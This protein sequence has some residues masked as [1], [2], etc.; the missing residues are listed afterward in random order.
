MAI[1]SPDLTADRITQWLREARATTT[2]E[3]A[4]DRTLVRSVAFS[5]HPGFDFKKAKRSLHRARM[6]NEIKAIRPFRA[7]RRNQEAVNEGLV[8]ALGAL[9]SVNKE[10]ASELE[11]L[12]NDIAN[13]RRQLAEREAATE[14]R[15]NGSPSHRPSTR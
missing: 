6:K 5:N 2:P 11:A 4:P 15:S 1:R 3:I 12:S 8:D 14:P 7:L 13:L 9:I 10:M